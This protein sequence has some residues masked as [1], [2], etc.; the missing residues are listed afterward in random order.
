M[1]LK[2]SAYY[3]YGFGEIALQIQRQIESSQI[4]GS[5]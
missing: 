4:G 5:K 1:I 3:L 2:I